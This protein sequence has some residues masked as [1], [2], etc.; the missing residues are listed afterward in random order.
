MNEW[1]NEIVSWDA[2]CTGPDYN[3]HLYTDIS[4]THASIIHTVGQQGKLGGWKTKK[5]QTNG[6]QFD[7]VERE[8]R[9]KGI[10]KRHTL[11]ISHHGENT[12]YAHILYITDLQIR[13]H[14]MDIVRMREFV[15]ERDALRW[16]LENYRSSKINVVWA[17]CAHTQAQTHILRQYDSRCIS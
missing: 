16:L 14:K 10:K 6:R 1:I 17:I 12:F 15:Q 5:K 11:K 9:E 7:V 4:D 8:W 2:N 13:T 3:F